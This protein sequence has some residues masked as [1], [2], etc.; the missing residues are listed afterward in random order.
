MTLFIDGNVDDKEEA[1]EESEESG[2]EDEEI[3]LVGEIEEADGDGTVSAI[4]E[5]CRESCCRCCC[6]L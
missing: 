6:S 5:C 3:E 2:E 4:S 1:C